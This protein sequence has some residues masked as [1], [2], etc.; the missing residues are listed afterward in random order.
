MLLG[1]AVPVSGSWATPANCVRI[2]RRAE[3]LGYASLWTFQRLLSPLDGDAPV[4]EPPYRSVQDP[5]AVLA[6]LAGQTATVRIGV[7]VV[8]MPYYAPIVLAKQLT[9]IDHLSGGRLDVGLGL[10][11]LPPELEA[12]GATTARRGARGEDFLRCLKAIWTH[13][14]VDYDGDFY[15]VARSRV[16]P[17]PVQRPHPPLLLGGTAEAA[18]RRTG[19]VA[20]GW[21]SSSR[22]D[23]SK[24]DETIDVVR[25]GAVDAGRDPSGLRFV[26]RGVVKL[27][28]EPGGQLVGPLDHIRSDLA[29]L[30]AKGV[31]ETFVDLNFDPEVGSPEAD[32]AASM[33]RAEEVLEAFAPR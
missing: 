27:R 1:F 22:A 10:G 26:C 33:D 21:I 17:K 15:R 5:L 6:Y 9:T 28:T 25:R 20:D 4:L 14:V 3:E 13:D 31:T 16:E 32:A 2:A 30:A 8:N 18:L 11:W 24:I 29:R 19:R 23:L 12:A 7:A